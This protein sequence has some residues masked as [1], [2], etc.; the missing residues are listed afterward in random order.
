[1]KIANTTLPDVKILS[2]QRFQDDRGFFC[3]TW[4]QQSLARAGI[5]I[6]FVQDNE[7]LSRHAG[8]LRG[9]HYQ[10]PPFAQ[11]KLVRVAAGA[12]WD[13]AVD[14]RTGSPDY[15]TWVGVELSAQNGQ[16][17]LV[18][19]GFLHGFVTLMPDTHVIYKVDNFYDAESDGALLWN[20]PDLGINWGIDPAAVILSGKDAR[21]PRFANW[22]SP[23]PY[24]GGA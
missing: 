19:R 13:V 20:D 1:M 23:F 2:P 4:N 10:A 12:I 17:L 15:G 24:G 16:Q 14:V 18:P 21:A 7:S 8:T 11:T 5:E 3:E 9:L 22:L 6:A